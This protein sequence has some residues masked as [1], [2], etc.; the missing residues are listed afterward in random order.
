MATITTRQGFPNIL[1]VTGTDVYAAANVTA[2]LHNA[3][4]SDQNTTS[5]KKRVIRFL[6]HLHAAGRG[7]S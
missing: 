1:V 2:A 6:Y 7:R 3:L 5:V 4:E